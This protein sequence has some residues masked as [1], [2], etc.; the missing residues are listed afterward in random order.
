MD[1]ELLKKSEKI[2][3]YEFHIKTLERRLR[4]TRSELEYEKKKNIFIIMVSI[5]CIVGRKFI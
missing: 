3:K 4:A 5:F 2:R 1:N